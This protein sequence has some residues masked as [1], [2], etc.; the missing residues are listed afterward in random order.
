MN[1]ILGERD[2]EKTATG[3][4]PKYNLHQMNLFVAPDCPSY[5]GISV[6]C[7]IISYDL[8]GK[9]KDE[10]DAPQKLRLDDEIKRHY[11][12]H[13]VDVDDLVDWDKY[14]YNKEEMQFTEK[15]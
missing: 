5:T 4:Y 10:L 2:Y 9:Y 14:D 11:G 6:V 8:F 7:N 13:N 1:L 12:I 3:K 15:V